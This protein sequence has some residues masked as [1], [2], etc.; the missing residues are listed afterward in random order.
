M[1]VTNLYCKKIRLMLVWLGVLTASFPSLS[2]E[3]AQNAE[4]AQRIKPCTACHGE[5]GRAGPDG[6]YPRLAGKPQGYLFHQM[7]NFVQGRRHYPLMRKLLDPLS[8]EYLQ[9]IA[10][11]FSKLNVSYAQVDKNK[12]QFSLEMLERGK[13]IVLYGDKANQ[14]PACVSCHSNDLMGQTSDVPGILGLPV[15]Y[16]NAQLSAWREG[17]RSTKA[18]D[19]MARISKLLSIKDSSAVAAWLSEQEVTG[20]SLVSKV[21]PLDQTWGC[22]SAPMLKHVGAK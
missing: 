11:Y 9:E 1:M 20:Q 8:D 17:K 4:M 15:A 13:A 16:M 14:I 18:P 21:E 19:C 5:Q 7:Q 10:T 3:S 12:K 6:Y 2:Q 22:A